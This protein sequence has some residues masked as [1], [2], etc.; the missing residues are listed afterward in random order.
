[1]LEVNPEKREVEYSK[2]KCG[3]ES[4][5][6]VTFKKVGTKLEI[7]EDD[8]GGGCCFEIPFSLAIKALDI[9]R[10]QPVVKNG[11]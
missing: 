2:G 10:T 9:L 7:S 6:S 4:Y 11:S 5:F 1:M 8:Y 3:T